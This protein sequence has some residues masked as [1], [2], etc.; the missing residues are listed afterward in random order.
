VDDIFMVMYQRASS[1]ESMKNVNYGDEFLVNGNA[2][3]GPYDLLLDI[4][5]I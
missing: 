3:D 1:L 5:A 2:D 4:Q